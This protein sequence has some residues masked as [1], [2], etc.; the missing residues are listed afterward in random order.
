MLKLEL[1]GV[2]HISCLGGRGGA[3]WCHYPRSCTAVYARSGA[4]KYTVK[5]QCKQVKHHLMMCFFHVS[6]SAKPH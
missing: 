2:Y 3:C 4:V 6:V 5:I 1:V